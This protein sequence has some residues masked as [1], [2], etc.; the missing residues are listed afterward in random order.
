MNLASIKENLKDNALEI[1]LSGCKEFPH[2]SEC[3]SKELWDYDFG[4]KIDTDILNKIEY[5]IIESS[6]IFKNV[7]ILG[8][9]PLDKEH[10][11]FITFIKYINYTCKINN[12]KLWL[13]TRKEIDAIPK[14]IK[15]YFDFIKT[16]KFIV[17]SYSNNF[18]RGG[19]NLFSTNQKVHTRETFI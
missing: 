13:F 12:K 18:K 1:Y 6:K 17:S 2:C 16:G 8:G 14:G 3:N 7:F 4:D 11:E 9:E 19:I 15:Q 10:N 5:K